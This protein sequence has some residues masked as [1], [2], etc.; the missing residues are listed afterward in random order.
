[1]TVIWGNHDYALATKTNQLKVTDYFVQDG[2][3]FSHGWNSMPHKDSV[4]S[5]INQSQTISLGF[6]N[7][8]LRLRL[9]VLGDMMCIQKADQENW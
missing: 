6:I 4:I 8:F 2:I 5:S 3:L 1:M 9:S 7:P